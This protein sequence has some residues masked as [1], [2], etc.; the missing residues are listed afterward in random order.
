MI[1]LFLVSLVSVRGEVIN[2]VQRKD[3][4]IT[5]SCPLPSSWDSCVFNHQDGSQEDCSLS[6]DQADQPCPFQDSYL[7]VTSVE[8]SRVCQLVLNKI[9]VRGKIIRS[10]M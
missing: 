7:H 10:L 9:K 5:L 6:P 3:S 8:G 2:I 4:S 1:I